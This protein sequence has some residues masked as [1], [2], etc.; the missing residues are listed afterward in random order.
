MTKKRTPS[1]GGERYNRFDLSIH[2]P[3]T[4]SKRKHICKQIRCRTSQYIEHTRDRLVAY[5]TVYF[6]F[7][8]PPY[9]L[10]HTVVFKS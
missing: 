9:Q 8:N 7:R 5:L 6:P 4:L 1:E 3:R 2:S 10:E